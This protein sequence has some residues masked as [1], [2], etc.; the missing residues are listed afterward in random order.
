MENTAQDSR[1]DVS[2]EVVQ[3]VAGVFH[4]FDLARELEGRGSLKCIYSTF[5]WKR[6]RREGIA[7]EKVRTFPW[8]HTPQLLVGRMWGIPAGLNRDITSVMFRTFDHWVANTMPS[9]D[10]YVALSGSGVLSGRR[11]QERGAKY[12]C[13]RGSSHIR[14][15]DRIVGE[16]YKR[17]G[18]E[19]VIC[20]PRIIAREETEYEEAD[21]IVVPSEFARRSFV[22]MG[23]PA[24]KVYKIP[25]GV[26][27]ERFRRTGEPM[28]D[29]FEVLFVGSVNLRKGVP[30]LLEGYRQLKHPRKRLR[31]VGSV[32]PEFRQILSGLPQEGVEFMGHVPQGQLP[33]LF[34]SSHVM[35]LPSIEEGL[36]L[37]QGQ[38]MA[39]GC[40]LISSD[41]TGGEDLFADGVEGFLT[42][43]RSPQAIGARLQQLAD[44]APLRE[45]MSEAAQERVR[46]IGG[47]Y[48]YGESW[49]A[50]AQSLVGS[51][52]AS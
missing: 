43:I 1:G 31:I 8:V 25:Y 20:D 50:F 22:E 42:P 45:R 14:Y 10:V 18:I 48:Q 2:L 27:L 13:D 32:A 11:A 49:S 36:A 24:E 28:P 39:C 15:Q 23:V 51:A 37:V 9:C 38:A 6:L 17:W 40:P 12:I 44:D 35:V 16:E 34:S 3:A 30:Y 41:H 29:R 47:W 46:H 33:A 19:R 4:H 5:P 21:A 52:P 26:R 7:L